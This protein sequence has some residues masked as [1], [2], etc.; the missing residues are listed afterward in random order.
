LEDIKFLWSRLSHRNF[1]EKTLLPCK[2]II[3][4]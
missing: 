3:Q 4:L 1:R 2:Y